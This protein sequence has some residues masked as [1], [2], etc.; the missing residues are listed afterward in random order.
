V[1]GLWA[2]QGPQVLQP[3]LRRQLLSSAQGPQLLSPGRGSRL[4]SPEES[5]QELR[6]EPRR[7]LWPELQRAAA[8]CR[9]PASEATFS[10]A[11]A[12]KSPPFSFSRSIWVSFFRTAR[13]FFSSSA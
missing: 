4:F 12:S 11:A 1:K 9:S 7:E 10:C 2:L 5:L 6:R 8:S 3:E 13:S